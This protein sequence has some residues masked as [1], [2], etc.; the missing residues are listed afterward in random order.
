MKKLYHINSI[1]EEDVKVFTPRIPMSTASDEDEMLTRICTS[2][3]VT[4]CM[5][6]HPSLIQDCGYFHSNKVFFPELNS[7]GYLYRVYHF[8]EKLEDIVEPSI[9]FSEQ[10]VPDAHETNEHWIMKTSTPVKVTYLIVY[11]ITTVFDEEDGSYKDI[12]IQ[13]E[14]FEDLPVF[15]RESMA[16]PF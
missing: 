7:H 16:T 13:F 11:S 12:N 3:L 9:L 10:L 2:D 5:H 6:A 15:V 14:E 8:E 4:G 1:F